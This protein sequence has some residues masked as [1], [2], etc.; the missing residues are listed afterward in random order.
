VA[1]DVFRVALDEDGNVDEA[2][3]RRL[4]NAGEAELQP[5]E[6]PGVTIR[7]EATS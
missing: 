3:T 5:L 2:G 4:R 6:P 7:R 1:G